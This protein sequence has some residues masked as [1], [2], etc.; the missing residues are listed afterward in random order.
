MTSDFVFESSICKTEVPFSS[1]LPKKGRLIKMSLWEFY[2]GSFLFRN[3]DLALGAVRII[4]MEDLT[5]L[6]VYEV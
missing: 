2:G 4:M 6:Y 1:G 5:T 3:C